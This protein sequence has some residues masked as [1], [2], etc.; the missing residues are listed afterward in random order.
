MFAFFFFFFYYQ[1]LPPVSSL[2]VKKMEE[3][4]KISYSSFLYLGAV[5]EAGE[6]QLAGMGTAAKNT[7]AGGWGRG[8]RLGM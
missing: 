2:A 4:G 3:T 1:V 5:V 8:R 6:V 7:A